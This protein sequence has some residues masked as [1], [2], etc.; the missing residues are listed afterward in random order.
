[1]TEPLLYAARPV[2]RTRGVV[3]EELARDLVRLEIEEDIA[4][5]KTLCARF[6]AL[7]HREGGVQEELQYLDGAVLDFGVDLVV[8]VGPEASARTVFRGRVSAIEAEFSEGEAPEVAVYAEDRLMDLRMTR[9]TRSYE[10]MSDADIVREIAAAHGLTAEVD[11]DELPHDVVQQWNQSDLAFLRERARLCRAELWCDDREHLHFSTRERRGGP[12]IAL[13]RGGELL[14]LQA[15]ADL[16]HQR[17][18]VYVSGFD[19][20]ARAGIDERADESAIAGEIGSG[21]S[22]PEVLKKAFG[23]RASQRVREVPLV[24]AAATSMARAE[25]QR[26]A[27]AFVQVQGVTSGTPDLAVGSRVTLER[28]GPPFSGGGYHVTAVRHT[29]DLARGLRT[30]FSAERPTIAGGP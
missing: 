12:E 19:A 4:G 11:V 23:A 10:D 3:R 13:V 26:R 24:V 2:L 20:D 22:G 7:A 17:T 21:R 8:S 15:R 30:E 25:L 16:A 6:V 1:M 27:R 29:Y 9:R 28:V 5:L 18:D 14:R